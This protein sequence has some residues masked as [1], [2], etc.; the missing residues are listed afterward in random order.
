MPK[1]GNDGDS[2]SRGLVGTQRCGDG[3]VTLRHAHAKPQQAVG[4]WGN[5][6]DR[7]RG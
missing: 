2:F 7:I 5:R 3:N 1:I 4:F 6:S